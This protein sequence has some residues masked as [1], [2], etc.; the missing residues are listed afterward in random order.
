MIIINTEDF[1]EINN[2][3]FKR[4]SLSLEEVSIANKKLAKWYREIKEKIERKKEIKN[5]DIDL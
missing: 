2:E 1:Q 4:N 3:Y 5:L